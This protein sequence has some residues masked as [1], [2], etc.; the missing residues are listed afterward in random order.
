MPEV[1]QKQALDLLTN[2][3]EGFSDPLEVREVF[4]ELF[5]QGDGLKDAD[6]QDPRLLIEHMVRY[7]HSGLGID[8]IVD[9]WGRIVPKHRNVWYNEI[10]D[11]IH[12]S[13]Q[14]EPWYAE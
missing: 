3:L 14:A 1:S 5:P 8:E 6:A 12:Y 4:H 11:K 10:D 2:K 13:E 7:L 9:L